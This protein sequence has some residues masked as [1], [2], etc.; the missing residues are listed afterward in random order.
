MVS[1]VPI[2]TRNIYPLKHGK[3]ST[4]NDPCASGSFVDNKG[5]AEVRLSAVKS[6]S[7]I[8]AMILSSVHQPLGDEMIFCCAVVMC[9]KASK[10]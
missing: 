6:I 1:Q 9:G 10:K 2:F 7:I 8:F 5:V 3:W 4:C